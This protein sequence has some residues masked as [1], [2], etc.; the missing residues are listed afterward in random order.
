MI[1]H[2]SQ[3]LYWDSTDHCTGALAACCSETICNIVQ[4]VNKS[5]GQFLSNQADQTYIYIYI[6]INLYYIILCYVILYCIAL[7]KYPE[8][9]TGVVCYFACFHLHDMAKTHQADSQT[10]ESTGGHR[11]LHRC[12]YPL[13]TDGCQ[14]AGGKL[15]QHWHSIGTA[16]GFWMSLAIASCVASCSCCSLFTFPRFVMFCH[17]LSYFLS[18]WECGDLA[19]FWRVLNIDTLHTLIWDDTMIIDDP[20]MW[21]CDHCTRLLCAT[22]W[23]GSFWPAAPC[24]EKL[25]SK[26]G[27]E[28]WSPWSP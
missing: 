9:Y 10:W 28:R 8:L 24:W 6:Y 19:R 7:Y 4:C 23:E 21:S 18:S 22:A 1:G 11:D 27:I 26:P 14:E 2:K 12:G 13:S 16:M 25:Q 15:A 3:A 17:V 5:L 20:L